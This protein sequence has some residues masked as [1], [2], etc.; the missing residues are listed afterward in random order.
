MLP[1]Y[2][3]LTYLAAPL[4]LALNLWRARGKPEH[5]AR[6]VE[7]WG[8]TQ[9]RFSSAPVWV[10]A[11]SVG[12]VQA[13]A[14]LVRALL[15]RYP[16]RA[17]L[18]TT[19]TATGAERVRSLFGQSVQHAYLPY[20]MPGAVRRF[21]DRVSPAIGIVMETEI[22][23]NLFRQC[24][25]RGIPILLA[26]ARLSQKSLQRFRYLSGLTRG[27]L[28]H[29][30]IAAQTSADAQRFEQIG[31]RAGNIRVEGNL[32]FDIQIAP[33]VRASGEALRAQQFPERA[34]W[35][36]ASTHE[37]EEA[38]ALAAHDLVRAAIPGALLVLVPRHPQRFAAVKALLAARQVPFASRSLQERVDASTQ[39]LLVDTLGELLSFY[40]C[41]DVA[42]VGGSLVPI[43]G[44][45]LLE[46][47][48]LARAILIGPH[49]FNAPET[50]ALLRAEGAALE[51]AD[52]RMLGEQ[53]ARLLLDPSERERMGAAARMVVE[54]NRGALERVLASVGE[55]IAAPRGG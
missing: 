2:S 41:A 46:P 9:A 49:N 30:R 50:A 21:L 32:K 25:E 37:G 53:V 38:A 43:G 42:F 7:R 17:I 52:E 31:A 36:A 18:V 13:A 44:H 23:P 35:I 8:Y 47:A 3:V 10:H 51:V 15:E 29:V 16:D 11:V 24:R 34:V 6:W 40:A 22:W 48:A 4:A 5:R 20:D 1:I 14:V 45:N 28:Q 54:R 12:E 33:D 26:S 55:L 39:V 27:A 19:G